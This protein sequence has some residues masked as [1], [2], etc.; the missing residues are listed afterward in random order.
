MIRHIVK[1]R[2]RDIQIAECI[3]TTQEYNK[4]KKL[5]NYEELESYKTTESVKRFEKYITDKIV[6]YNLNNFTPDSRG[7]IKGKEGDN[8]YGYLLYR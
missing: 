5:P 6:Q 4:I 1:Y 7:V 2:T 8:N 3:C